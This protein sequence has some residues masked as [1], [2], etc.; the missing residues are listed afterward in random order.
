MSFLTQWLTCRPLLV[1]V[2][3]AVAPIV[4]HATPQAPDQII[5]K[6]RYYPLMTNP[7]ESFY[8]GKTRPRFFFAP[9]YRSSG[10]FRGYIATW[11]ILENRLFL[12]AIDTW[13]CE[14][15]IAESCQRVD[16]RDLFGK[17]YRDGRVEANW[18][19]GDLRLANGRILRDP[20]TGYAAI[21]EHE[22]MLTVKSGRMVGEKHVDYSKRELP[23]V[24]ELMEQELQKLERKDKQKS[25]SPKKPSKTPRR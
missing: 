20:W 25:E 22:I 13:I 1:L 16:L 8:E 24:Y 5:Y 3:F 9:G 10:N 15:D 23:S 18:Y 12:V 7:L 2:V 4:V 17:K 19:S 6:G 21:F 11:E 14:S